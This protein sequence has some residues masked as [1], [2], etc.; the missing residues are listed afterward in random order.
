MEPTAKEEKEGEQYYCGQ[1]N[2][3]RVRWIEKELWERETREIAIARQRRRLSRRINQGTLSTGTSATV[4][5]QRGS[6]STLTDSLL[7]PS[8]DLSQKR[9]KR[10][11]QWHF[12]MSDKQ[13]DRQTDWGLL[14][15]L[16]H[17]STTGLD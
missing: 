15:P 17:S 13:K 4:T 5:A 1:L 10:C 8:W 12:F 7:S 2:A 16:Q 6:H 3:G 9:Q 14:L 11:R